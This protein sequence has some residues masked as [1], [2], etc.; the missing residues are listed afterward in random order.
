M[1][2]P[3]HLV[4]RCLGI[5]AFALKSPNSHA[6][7]ETH[8]ACETGSVSLLGIDAFGLSPILR[9]CL[10]SVHLGPQ[11]ESLTNPSKVIVVPPFAVAHGAEPPEVFPP[12]PLL[13]QELNGCSCCHTPYMLHQRFLPAHTKEH[14]RCT[15][16]KCRPSDVC[17][18]KSGCLEA[19]EASVAEEEVE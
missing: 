11:S 18:W 10:T 1:S 19:Q 14:L 6:S 7:G 2:C 16:Q 8:S 4:S 12:L 15:G 9:P 17:L 3:S 5:K 13:R